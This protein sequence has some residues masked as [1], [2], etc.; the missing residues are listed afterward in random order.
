MSFTTKGNFSPIF[1]IGTRKTVPYIPSSLVSM[2]LIPKVYH[3]YIFFTEQYTT[4]A[5]INDTIPDKKTLF[6][7]SYF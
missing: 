6:F 7:A 1:A 4:K 3:T 2:S 5:R